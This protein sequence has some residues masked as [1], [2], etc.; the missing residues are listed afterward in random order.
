MNENE[1]S[2]KLI[3]QSVSL[4]WAE[5]LFAEADLGDS[6]RTKRLIQIAGNV[7]SA[8]EQSLLSSCGGEPAMVEGLYRWLENTA[9]DHKAIVDAGSAASTHWLRMVEGDIIA[10]S[11]TSNIEVP[12]SLRHA[13]GPLRHGKKGGNGKRGVLVHSTVFQSAQTGESLGLGDQEYWKRSDETMGKKHQRHKRAYEDKES[14]KWEAAIERVC[15]KFPEFMRRFIFTMDREGDIYELLTY[16]FNQRLR[17]V[18][19]ASFNRRTNVP[20]QGILDAVSTAPLLGRVRVDISQKGGRKGRDAVLEIRSQRVSLQSP[21]EKKYLPLLDV[22][23]VHIREPN[24]KDGLCWTLLTSEPVETLEDALYV[25]RAY[26]LRWK[27]EEFHN[28]WK[29][30]GVN[31][32]GLRLQ[33]EGALLKAAAVLAFSAIR[34]AQLREEADPELLR[35]RTEMEII[36]RK[37]ENINECEGSVFTKGLTLPERPCTTVLSDLEWRILWAHRNKGK[38]FPEEIP[39]RTWAYR[40]IGHLG[41]WFDS[42]HTGRVGIK[43]FWKGYWKLQAMVSGY[44]LAQQAGLS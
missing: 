3:I 28:T 2:Q 13:L 42:K 25:V 16:L 24:Q 6:R 30:G 36:S 41:G 40:N 39:T 8:P 38:P 12:H 35:I 44:L 19:R 33:T 34:L 23:V 31:V 4:S 1:Q 32:E 21:S 20:Q 5:Q 17:Y 27:V 22:N 11:D 37:E 7:V 26:R 10:A 9:I 14:F 15:R 29:S 18:I 43:A